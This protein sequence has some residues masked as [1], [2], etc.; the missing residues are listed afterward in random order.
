[1]RERGDKIIHPFRASR[2]F[3][4]RG[5]QQTFLSERRH[6]GTPACLM[7]GEDVLYRTRNVAESLKIYG[8]KMY[9]V[10]GQR[11]CDIC[12][13]IP[14]ILLVLNFVIGT[15]NYLECLSARFSDRIHHATAFPAFLNFF[16]PSSCVAPASPFRAS[17]ISS[18]SPVW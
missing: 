10:C 5:D 16:P 18:A 4:L 3:H 2:K 1:M 15:T 6:H 17:S 8:T 11:K 9:H 12:L 7:Y 13:R 14:F